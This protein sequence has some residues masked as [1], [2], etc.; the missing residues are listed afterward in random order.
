MVSEKSWFLFHSLTLSNSMNDFIFIHNE[1]ISFEDL[2]FFVIFKI[3]I[4]R[5]SSAI[6]FIVTKPLKS[7][8]DESRSFVALLKMVCVC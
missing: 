3:W 2:T 5:D 6:F 1:Y 7:L 8:E 4:G